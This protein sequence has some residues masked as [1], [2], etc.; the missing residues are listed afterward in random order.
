MSGQSDNMRWTRRHLLAVEDLSASEIVRI[1]DTAADFK[2]RAEQGEPK[3]SVLRGSV[4]ANLFFEPSTRTKMSFSL[5][6]KRLSADT[7]DFTASGSSLSK[8]N[9]RASCRERV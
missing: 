5:A 3:S 1:L 4:V 9:G 8:E 7:V 6:A 2:Q